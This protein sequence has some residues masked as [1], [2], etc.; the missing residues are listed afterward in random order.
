MLL[1]FYQVFCLLL[2]Y[3]PSSLQP[4]PRKKRKAGRSTAVPAEEQAEEVPKETVV[5]A[6]V[7]AIEKMQEDSDSKGSSSGSSSSDSDSDSGDEG[8]EQP[9]FIP[10]SSFDGPRAGYV[11]KNDDDGLGYYLEADSKANG[12]APKVQQES[13]PGAKKSSG[14]DKMYALPTRDEMQQLRQADIVAKANMYELELKT[15]LKRASLSYDGLTDLEQCLFA[16]KNAFDKMPSQEVTKDSTCMQLCTGLGK[17]HDGHTKPVTLSFAKPARVDLVGSYLLHTLVKP[18]LNVDVAVEMPSSCF[19]PKDFLDY[20]YHD[21]RLLYLSAIAHAL[22]KDKKAFSEVKI[23]GFREG[24]D[25]KPILVVILNSKDKRTKGFQIRIFPV[26]AAD[27]FDQSKLGP[28]KGNLKAHKITAGTTQR[29][30]TPRYNCTILE[31]AYLKRHLQILHAAASQSKGFIQACQL[32]KIWLRRRGMTGAPDSFNGFLMSL[33]VAHLINMNQVNRNSSAKQIFNKTINFIV[34]NDFGKEGMILRDSPNVDGST[35][36][37]SVAALLAAHVAHHDVVLLDST[38]YLNVASRVSLDA[39]HELRHQAKLTQKCLKK[40]HGSTV[41]SFDPLFL[42]SAL[43]FWKRYDQYVIA[44]PPAEAEHAPWTQE[45]LQLMNDILVQALGDR[46]TLVRVQWSSRE[47]NMWDVSGGKPAAR[48]A[49]ISL[50]LNPGTFRRTLDKGPPADDAAKAKQ[51]RNF[52]GKR[53]ELRRFRDGSIIEAVLWACKSGREHRIV[54]DVVKY[55]LAR[56]MAAYV[57]TM[58]SDVNIRTLSHQ[59]DQLLDTPGGASMSPD[60]MFKRL[61]QTLDKLSISLLAIDTLPLRVTGLHFTGP[62]GRYTREIPPVL[63]P[64]L[65]GVE[66]GMEDEGVAS[67]IVSPYNVAMTIETSGRWPDDLGA[68]KKVKTAFLCNLGQTLRKL[69]IKS[70]ANREWLDVAFEGY[71]FRLNLVCDREQELLKIACSPVPVVIAGKRKFIYEDRVLIEQKEGETRLRALRLKTE[72]TRLHTHLIHNVHMKN[73][74]YGQVARLAKRWLHSKM[75]SDVFPCETVELMVA[76]LF[77][78]PSC[79]PHQPP[80]SAIVGLIRFLD[81][82]ATFSWDFEPLIVNLDG[83]IT[84][85]EVLRIEKQFETLQ[86]ASK[87]NAKKDTTPCFVIAPYDRE[88]EWVPSWLLNGQIDAV[89]MKRATTLA[90]GAVKSIQDNMAVRGSGNITSGK[91]W[92]K[93]FSSCPLKD[94][95]AVISIRPECLSYESALVKRLKQSVGQK[96]KGMEDSSKRIGKRFRVRTYKNLITKDSLETL[97]FGFDPFAQYVET[98]RSHFGHLALF[99]RNALHGDKVGIVWN[100]QA[101]APQPFKVSTARVT[102]PS[103]Q[104]KKKNKS[105]TSGTCVP[106]QE[107]LL[108]EIMLLGK[109]FVQ[110]ISHM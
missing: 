6:N 98:L 40:D 90:K 83:R 57:G 44:S 60:D 89:C 4:M 22:L 5:D 38:G 42:G 96:R 18:S 63:H 52:W 29:K 86:A 56:H 95:D 8:E 71:L 12:A 19:V 25:T 20:R 23:R 92:R 7:F 33:L 88:Q 66:P 80:V 47:S 91:F 49:V 75:L 55:A 48:S 106:N 39:Y 53:S 67:K 32:F 3:L 77:L 51:F 10:S 85:A 103:H 28:T 78:E 74:V 100:A 82:L 108:G 36:A 76:S 94:Y 41:N 21:K 107:E 104:F 105:A 35:N 79:R 11:F 101:F 2:S 109:G 97:M 24:N 64:L 50:L 59:V 81:L 70:V 16:L 54:G 58:D 72:T 46:V 30:A 62:G 87:G 26:I 110:K 102:T 99:F 13:A 15:L 68:I 9:L 45:T 61:T 34:K 69:D 14:R 31:D 84:D 27:E 37:N 17:L 1:F 93:V 65:G 43:G 73:G